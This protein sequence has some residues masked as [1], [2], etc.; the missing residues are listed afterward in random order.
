MALATTS[1]TIHDSLAAILTEANGL[2]GQQFKKT[3][4]ELFSTT[5]AN[6]TGQDKYTIFGYYTNS[7]TSGSAKNVS[8]K[9]SGSY[10]IWDAVTQLAASFAKLRVLYA[11]NFDTTNSI[12]VGGGTNNLSQYAT[13]RT[14]G[15]ATTSNL[16]ILKEVNPSS[17]GFTV[18]AATAEYIQVAAAAGT[19]NFA[20]I[21]AG[22]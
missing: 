3:L 11:I 7:V 9:G 5:L 21:V 16:S 22:E 18:T 14:L 8:L 4:T 17:A 2:S 19:C 1:L 6:G 13:A 10:Y 15:P 12:T 20:L